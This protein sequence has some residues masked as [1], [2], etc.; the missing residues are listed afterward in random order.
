MKEMPW[1]GLINFK[2][3]PRILTTEFQKFN[4][5]PSSIFL[6]D[7]LLILDPNQR[8][9][10][11]QALEHQ[12]F[13]TELPAAC[14]R[15]RLPV[16]DGDWHEFEG[17]QRKKNPQPQ[18]PP[19]LGMEMNSSQSN[20][21]P[22]ISMQMAQ[23]ELPPGYVP[24]PGEIRKVINVPE[25]LIKLIIGFKGSQRE[26][27]ERKCGVLVHIV[28]DKVMVFGE[29]SRVADAEEEIGLITG[30]SQESKPSIKFEVPSNAVN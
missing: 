13:T 17:K 24:R 18:C 2:E 26:E 23:H 20:L 4:L 15:H 28:Q 1:N 6:L 11:K 25:H 16:I 14:E 3:Y 19:D 7:G 30:A 9:T 5:S 29:A 12:Y 21:L 10:C 27:I 22:N 8:L